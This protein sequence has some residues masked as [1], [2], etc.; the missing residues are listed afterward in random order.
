[1]KVVIMGLRVA[2]RLVLR[3]VAL[4]LLSAL[5][6]CQQQFGV[7]T[8]ASS[9]SS[10]SSSTSPPDMN[11]VALP[12]GSF[13]GYFTNDEL[14]DYLDTL[15]ERDPTIFTPSV[16]IGHSVENRQIKAICAG[17]CARPSTNRQQH[18]GGV[19]GKSGSGDHVEDAAG[20]T[21]SPPTNAPQVRCRVCE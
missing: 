13:G 8:A 5:L 15:V 10:S 17:R 14:D 9:S 1:M 6:C 20:D 7:A 12:Y 3:R 4:V 18:P 11:G 16:V 2:L 21:T 19:G